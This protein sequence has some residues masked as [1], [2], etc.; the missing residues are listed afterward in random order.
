MNCQEIIQVPVALEILKGPQSRVYQQLFH[1]IYELFQGSFIYWILKKYNN[2]SSKEKLWNDAKDAFQMGIVKMI[3]KSRNNELTIN[4]SL[5][6]TVY[7]YGLLQLLA[8]VKKEKSEEKRKAGYLT[9]IDL[10]IEDDGI[11]KETGNLFDE[12]EKALL[13]ALNE[14][15]QKRRQ[16]LLMAFYGKLRSKEIAGKLGVSAGNVDNEKAK[17]YKALR[18]LLKSKF[19]A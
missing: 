3:E 11:V 18:E 15:P 5:K 12:R 16:I 14:L 13:K 4:G 19:L 17:A 8:K 10:F 6:T 7:S 2:I 9:V 1:C